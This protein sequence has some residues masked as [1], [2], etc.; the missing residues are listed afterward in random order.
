MKMQY[1]S[2]DKI[3][4]NESTDPE[5]TEVEIMQGWEYGQA[6]EF[7]QWWDTICDECNEKISYCWHRSVEFVNYDLCQSCVDN[8]VK[9][10]TFPEIG[11]IPK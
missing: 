8:H 6:G 1:L 3:M 4:E 9:N 7:Y 11:E 2:L 10:Q 5:L